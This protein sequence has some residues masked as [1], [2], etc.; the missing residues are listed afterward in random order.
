MGEADLVSR[1]TFTCS[2]TDCHIPLP[3]PHLAALRAPGLTPFGDN[4]YV[5]TV[6]G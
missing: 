3:L 4:V 2:S 6:L 5:M 1:S